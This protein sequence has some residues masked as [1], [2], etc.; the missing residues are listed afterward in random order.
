MLPLPRSL[1]GGTKEGNAESSRDKRR[2]GKCDSTKD[3]TTPADNAGWAVPA[4]RVGAVRLDGDRRVARADNGGSVG[5]EGGNDGGAG[6]GGAQPLL[7]PCLRS[8]RRQME[9][10][11]L[12]V[13]V[14]PLRSPACP[15]CGTSRAP[16]TIAATPDTA[17]GAA[18]RDITSAAAAAA[19][20]SGEVSPFSSARASEGSSRARRRGR[21]QW[22]VGG[23]RFFPPAPDD[24]A[25]TA[26]VAVAGDR[27]LRGASGGGADDN[28]GMEATAAAAGA[29]GDA[30]ESGTAAVA[31]GS[32]ICRAAASTGAVTTAAVDGAGGTTCVE[33]AA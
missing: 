16:A 14:A 25:A 21:D 7:P 26:A 3:P 2:T 9:R 10:P 30:D 11:R 5:S 4:E 17:T 19:A 18:D 28:S 22:L 1:S 32:R 24:R 31:L 8:S 33:E 15:S 6:G 29:G 20:A 23:L 27:D 12:R 13:P